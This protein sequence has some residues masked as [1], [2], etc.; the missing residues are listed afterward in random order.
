MLRFLCTVL[1]LS[2]LISAFSIRA[3]EARHRHH[4][5]PWCGIYMSQITGHHDR[6]LWMAR[7]W[8]REGM[9]AGGPCVG[10]IVVWRHHVGRIEGQTASGEW[11]VHSGN[12]GG[13]V[14]T[15]PRSIAGAIAFRRL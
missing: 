8:A 2:V 14:R 15:R 11:I 7:E 9:N 5:L 4:G 12:D 10:C 3:A 13:R 6:R 1:S